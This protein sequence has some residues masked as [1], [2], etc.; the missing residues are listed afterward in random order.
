M[1]TTGA[2]TSV[3]VI[4]ILAK[5][6]FSAY[7]GSMLET[8]T[9]TVGVDTHAAIK[10]LQVDDM[11]TEAQAE[12]I[13][14]RIRS[15]QLYGVATS[16]QLQGVRDELKEDIQNVR[17]VLKDDVQR[18]EEKIHNVEVKLSDFVVR[19]S[20]GAARSSPVYTPWSSA[21]C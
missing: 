2:F 20:N 17:E 7:C 13:I 1:A 8:Y 4:K 15:V 3:K 5:H 11:F 12:A 19:Y 9:T 16:T 6:L 10:A 21:C 18:L 14:D